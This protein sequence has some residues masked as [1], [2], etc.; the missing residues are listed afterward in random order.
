MEQLLTE[1]CALILLSAY[2]ICK[3]NKSSGSSFLYIF[4][5]S[6][7]F[8]APKNPLL[9]PLKQFIILFKLFELLLPLLSLDIIAV[10]TE[11]SKLSLPLQLL[12]FSS[13]TFNLLLLALFPLLFSP[14]SS[15]LSYLFLAELNTNC[16]LPKI[17]GSF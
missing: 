17:I 8:L 10:D 15:S 7:L 13:F 6:G 11:L 16:C 5:I 2:L 12:L 1:R 14:N 9:S 3:V 4:F